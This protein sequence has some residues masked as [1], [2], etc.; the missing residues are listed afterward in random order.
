MILLE[1]VLTNDSL[2]DDF[3]T[4]G[5][6]KLDFEKNRESVNRLVLNFIVKYLASY[7]RVRETAVRKIRD[8]IVARLEWKER[9]SFQMDPQHGMQYDAIYG[10]TRPGNDVYPLRCAADLWRTA[11]IFKEV[12]F[13]RNSGRDSRYVG[14]ELGSGTGILMAGMAIAAKRQRITDTLLVGVERSGKAVKRSQETL[15]SVLGKGVSSVLC[16]NV[17]EEGMLGKLFQKPIHHWVSETISLNTPK[18]DLDAPGFGLTPLQLRIRNLEAGSDPFVEGLRNSLREL[19]DFRR[20]V[21]SGKTAMFPNV[22]KGDYRPDG[23]RSTLVLRTS[24]SEKPVRLERTS[25]E[26]EVYEDLR[27]SDKRWHSDAE[28]ERVAIVGD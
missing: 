5:D 27:T 20:N 18:L 10:G 25:E 9:M 15:D 12:A 26:F 24:K 2:K 19:P 7:L 3:G 6:P 11:A 8:E 1:E 28:V 23:G 13:A 4:L 17:L 14:L 22:I 21:E 16:R